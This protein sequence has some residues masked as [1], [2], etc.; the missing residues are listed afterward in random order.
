[1]DLGVELGGLVVSMSDSMG[2]LFKINDVDGNITN[3]PLFFV[4]KM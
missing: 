3:A 4:E 2:L 1:M